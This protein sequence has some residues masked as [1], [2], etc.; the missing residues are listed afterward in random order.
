MTEEEKINSCELL[1]KIA[2]FD[3][4]SEE[5]TWTILS[6]FCPFG[7]KR[8]VNVLKNGEQCFDVSMEPISLTT[9]RITSSNGINFE[10]SIIDGVEG[11]TKEMLRFF[12]TLKIRGAHKWP[13]RTFGDIPE[14]FLKPMVLTHDSVAFVSIE[15]QSLP[16]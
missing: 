11:G 12:Y 15:N 3:R 8:T 6:E 9:F 7:E 10:H 14:E 16:M 5:Y 4:K 13:D 1:E 2:T